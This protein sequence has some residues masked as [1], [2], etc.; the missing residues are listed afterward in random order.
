MNTKISGKR[1]CYLAEIRIPDCIFND[2]KFRLVPRNSVVRVY[3]F[4]MV[5]YSLYSALL[6]IRAHRE[7]GD[8]WEEEGL[9]RELGAVFYF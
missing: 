2:D 8:I 3:V 7:Y 6:L 1:R 4:Q 5:T 9:I